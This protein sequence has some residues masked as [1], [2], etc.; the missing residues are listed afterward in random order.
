[1][2]AVLQLEEDSRESLE[3]EHS[4]AKVGLQVTVAVSSSQYSY[5][6]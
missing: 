1:M 5:L 3:V 6:G 4:E 2:A